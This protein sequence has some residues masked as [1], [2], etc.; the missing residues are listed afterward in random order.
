MKFLN[1]NKV[2]VMF[3]ANYIDL[4]KKDELDDRFLEY[5]VQNSNGLTDGEKYVI[6]II[7]NK[8]SD[9]DEPYHDAMS[10]YRGGM[11]LSKTLLKLSLTNDQIKEYDKVINNMIENIIKY[12]LKLSDILDFH[13]LKNTAYW[14]E[15]PIGHMFLTK[16]QFVYNNGKGNIV[17]QKTKSSSYI[18]GIIIKGFEDVDDFNIFHARIYATLLYYLSKFDFDKIYSDVMNVDIK[19]LVLKMRQLYSQR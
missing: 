9:S 8:L 1:D 12:D 7:Y 18:N 11:Y 15:T 19:Q 16:Y 3:V 4:A 17:I 2:Y 14:F 6:N 13:G 5:F 10:I